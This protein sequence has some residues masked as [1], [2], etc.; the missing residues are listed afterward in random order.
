RVERHVVPAIAAGPILGLVVVAILRLLGH[1]RPGLVHLDLAGRRRAGDQFVV[2][3][4]GLGAGGAGV[5][6][7]GVGMDLDQPRRREDTTTLGDVLEDRGDRLLG[8]VGA[9]QR[10]ALALREAGA[11]GTTI[12]QAILAVLSEP[13]G[14][15]EVPGA[16]PS[17]V[18]APGIEATGASEVF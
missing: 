18:R 16:A 11:A 8:Q 1:E 10:G 12:E 17:G 13:A 5:A 15:G 6:A 7:D 2:R 9:I 4:F 3:G 14:D